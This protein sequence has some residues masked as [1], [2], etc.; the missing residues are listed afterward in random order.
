M[1]VLIL[2]SRAASVLWIKAGRRVY[3]N[4]GSYNLNTAC[5]RVGRFGLVYRLPVSRNQPHKPY[6]SGILFYVSVQI[7]GIARE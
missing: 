3:R 6:R 7:D 2:L 1:S 4:I 5:I